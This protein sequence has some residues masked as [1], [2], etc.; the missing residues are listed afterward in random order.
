MNVNSNSLFTRTAVFS[1][2]LF[3]KTAEKIKFP[4]LNQNLKKSRMYFPSSLYHSFILFVLFFITFIGHFLEIAVFLLTIAD[5]IDGEQAK[6]AAVLTGILIVLLVAFAGLFLFLLP[7]FKAY[8]RKIKI[9]QQLTFAVNYMAAMSIAGVSIENIFI[10][11]SQKRIRSV[12][13]ELSDEMKTI[14]VQV[15]YFGKDYPSAL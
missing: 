14:A 9:E 13:P 10:S 6:A 12:Y 3:G 7:Y 15:N 5:V 8:D 4:F 1:Y 11:M 2:R